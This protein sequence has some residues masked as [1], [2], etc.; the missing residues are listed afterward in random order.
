MPKRVLVPVDFSEASAE[1][2]RRAV[3]EV[4]ADGTLTVL[5]VHEAPMTVPAD[6]MPVSADVGG[7]ATASLDAQRGAL[8]SWVE[9]LDLGL[10]AGRLRI[11]LTEGVAADAIVEAAEAADLV[12]MPTHGR[13]GLRRWLLGSVAERV[14]R[15]APCS[16]LVV[17]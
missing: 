13:Q 6:H 1:A 14:V 9:G 3:E 16:V 4:G 10:D 11:D 12:V 5:H 15:A 8:R 2:A 17:R 7:G